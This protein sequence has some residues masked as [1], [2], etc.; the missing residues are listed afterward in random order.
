[1]N[2]ACDPQRISRAVDDDEHVGPALQYGSH[3][4][5]Q[6]PDNPRQPSRNCGKSDDRE[7]VDRQQAVEPGCS[8]LPPADACEPQRYAGTL[9]QRMHQSRAQPIARFLD[10]DQENLQLAA[11]VAQGDIAAPLI[12]A[13]SRRN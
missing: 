6:M 9:S 4:Q 1:M 8:H 3:R 5:A 7:I 11:L 12:M 13:R 10:G 2:A